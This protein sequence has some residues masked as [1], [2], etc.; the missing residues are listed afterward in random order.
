MK[1]VPWGTC[2]LLCCLA[3]VDAAI[4]CAIAANRPELRECF[5]RYLVNDDLLTGLPCRSH[6]GPG[7]SCRMLWVRVHG[8][9]ARLHLFQKCVIGKALRAYPIVMELSA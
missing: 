2:A 1:Q 4:G 9:T 3:G 7:A 8:Q 5:Q 6:A